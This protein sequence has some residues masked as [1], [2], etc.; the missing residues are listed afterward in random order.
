MFCHLVYLRRTKKQKA[1]FVNW[2]LKCRSASRC[3]GCRILPCQFWKWQLYPRVNTA[4]WLGIK[5]LF[6]SW[7]TWE[8][9]RSQPWQLRH[10]ERT[11]AH[12]ETA[13]CWRQET[14]SWLPQ[15]SLDAFCL[16][17]NRMLYAMTNVADTILKD[18]VLARAPLII[19]VF[20][21]QWKFSWEVLFKQ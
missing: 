8:H 7:T 14:V 9:V 5:K 12:R 19:S 2:I 18:M 11:A 16:Y 4:L 21:M 20:K 6:F 1:F 13:S 10:A 3:S 17:R 15:H